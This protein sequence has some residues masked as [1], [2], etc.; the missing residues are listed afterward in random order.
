MIGAL[1]QGE[2]L[3]WWLMQG[4][5]TAFRFLEDNNFIIPIKMRGA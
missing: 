4:S 5:S 1:F 2:K 3:E